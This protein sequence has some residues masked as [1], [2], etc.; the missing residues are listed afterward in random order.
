FFIQNQT[1]SSSPCAQPNSH[2]KNCPA[3][4]AVSR[5]AQ[6]ICGSA[7]SEAAA[8][9]TTHGRHTAHGLAH[10]GADS[11]AATPPTSPFI[12]STAAPC[13]SARHAPI[14]ITTTKLCACT[15]GSSPAT[16]PAASIGVKAKGKR[17]KAKE[18]SEA[19]F[20]SLSTSSFDRPRAFLPRAALLPPLALLLTFFFTSSRP[21][22]RYAARL[23]SPAAVHY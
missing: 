21:S 17:Q 4:T 7:S 15:S 22:T 5:V 23:S 2:P 19:A 16:S 8:A 3:R 14:N 1:A 18:E 11:S 12:R 10:A 6:S 13:I 9:N 20:A